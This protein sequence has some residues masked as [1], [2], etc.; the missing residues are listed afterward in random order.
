MLSQQELSDRFAIQDL[1]FHY[2][3]L[4]DTRQ[5]DRLREDVFTEDA[6]IDYSAFG[7]SV[8]DLEETIGFLKAS[9]TGEL[10]PNTQHLNANVQVELDGDRARGAVDHAIERHGHGGHD[11]P[12]AP[13]WR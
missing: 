7:G 11:T 3:N 6:H 9:L 10:F 2:A 1:V 4:I 13:P 5:F 8:G 12:S